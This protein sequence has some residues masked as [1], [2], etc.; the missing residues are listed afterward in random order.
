MDAGWFKKRKKMAGITDADIAAIAGRNRSAVP[1]ILGGQQRMTMIWARAFSQALGVSLSEVLQHA[2]ELDEGPRVTQ[3]HGF[4]ESDV[5]PLATDTMTGRARTLAEALGAGR[6]GIDTWRV[7]AT[8]LALIG[9][10]PGDNLLVDQHAGE[11]AKAGDVVIA[12][13]YDAASGEAVTVLRE[14]Q[15]PVLVPASVNPAARR[16][17]V[18]D[19]INVVVRGRVV[20]SWRDM[21]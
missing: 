15:P 18:V 21:P 17:H 13:V 16:V 11:R 2:G 4:S 1:K 20:S 8:D 9:F 6:T 5:A 7:K 19:G 3:R 14:Y 12:Q 10:L